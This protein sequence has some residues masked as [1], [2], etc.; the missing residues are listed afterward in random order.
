MGSKEGVVI[1]SDIEG[2]SSDMKRE[3]I[4]CKL[5]PAGGRLLGSKPRGKSSSVLVILSANGD[6]LS[7]SVPL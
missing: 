1:F 7:L 5:W 6:C 4:K 2:V 3:E